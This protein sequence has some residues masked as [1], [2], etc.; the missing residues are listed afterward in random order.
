MLE[1]GREPRDS[2]G[3]A[4]R[5]RSAVLICSA[6]DAPFGG[7]SGRVTLRC[8]SPVVGLVEKV[9]IHREVSRADML[10]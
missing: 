6:A 7:E 2:R 5:G 4:F 9:R 8:R 10:L 3:K 1:L